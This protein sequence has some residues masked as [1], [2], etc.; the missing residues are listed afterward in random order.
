M[1]VTF[2]T[3]V[4]ADITMFGHVAEALLRMMGQ[5]GAVPGA[6]L[7][8]DVPAALARLK[9]AIERDGALPGP[10]VPGATPKRD[11]DEEAAPPVNLRQR[12]F[13]LIG[14]LEAAAREKE[15]VTWAPAR[16]PLL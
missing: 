4:W 9:S 5:S 1:L 11:N 6:L 12:A 10:E 16:S 13:P 15:D 8:P 7:A 14:L 3:A 2:R